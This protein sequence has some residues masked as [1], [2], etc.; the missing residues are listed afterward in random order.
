MSA[1]IAGVLTL[2]TRYVA[3]VQPCFACVPACPCVTS[4]YVSE[5]SLSPFA[6]QNASSADI[7]HAAAWRASLPETLNPK[8]W[9]M[10]QVAVAWICMQDSR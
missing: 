6:R 1:S 10:L 7:E 9:Q 4:L 5:L 2:S 8:P 3:P